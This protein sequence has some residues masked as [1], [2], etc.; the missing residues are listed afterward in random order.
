[1]TSVDL[2]RALALALEAVER[3]PPEALILDFGEMA[4]QL[5]AAPEEIR[6]TFEQ[7]DDLDLIEGPGLHREAWMF[8]RLSPLGRLFVDEIR[9]LKRWRAIKARYNLADSE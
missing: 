1:M 8:R 9:H 5:N 7:L 3:S 6:I 2:V 4:G